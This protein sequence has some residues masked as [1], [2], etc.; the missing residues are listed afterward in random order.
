MKKIR[1]NKN[2][3]L[4]YLS[5]LLILSYFIYHNIFI[6]FVG[7][8]YSYYLLK[9]NIIDSFIKHI[10]KNKDKRKVYLDLNKKPND[11]ET[12]SNKI[13]FIEEDLTPRLAE[14]IEELGYIPS[15]NKYNNSEAK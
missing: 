13:R 10:N 4:E 11:M 7:T 5:I 2:K 15:P 8:A 9:K 6:V 3:I 1:D 12:D 14:I